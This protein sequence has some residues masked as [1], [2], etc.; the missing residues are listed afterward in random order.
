MTF[1][2][3]GDDVRQ[4]GLAESRR[5]EDQ[6]VIQRLAAHARRLNEDLHLRLD[7]RLPDVIGEGLGPHRAIDDLVL[8]PA[9]AGD[10]P[11]LFDAHA[12]F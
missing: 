11:I 6:H 1:E 7:V 5:P 3:V 4:R 12:R 2:L 8:A 10:D 9:G